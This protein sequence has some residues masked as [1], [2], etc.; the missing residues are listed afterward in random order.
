MTASVPTP[1]LKASRMKLSETGVL[2]SMS[3]LFQVVRVPLDLK[4]W[5][6]SIVFLVFHLQLLCAHAISLCTPLACRMSPTATA[7]VAAL[8]ALRG[9]LILNFLPVCNFSW[10]DAGLKFASGC[11]LLQISLT[12]HPDAKSCTLTRSYAPLLSSTLSI[13][14]YGCKRERADS[15]LSH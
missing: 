1:C 14:K 8:C 5:E 13:W 7:Y 12:P 15:S 4:L 3:P 11:A 2:S 9:E 10:L 6:V